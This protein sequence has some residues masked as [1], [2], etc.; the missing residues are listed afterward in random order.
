MNAKIKK[1]W[2]VIFFILFLLIFFRKTL[3]F[4]LLPIPGDLLVSFFFPYYSGGFSS[5]D[6]WTTHKGQIADDTIRQQYPWKVLTAKIWSQKELPLWNPYA[7]SGYPQAANFQTGA[8]YPLNILFIIIDPKTAWTLLIILQPILSA[9]FMY[10]FL[11]SQKM[12]RVASVFGS[13][14]FIGMSFEILWHEQMIIG[15]T[16]LWLP[17]ILLTIQ[18]VFEGR[19]K[20]L[21]LGI[22]SITMSVLAGYAQTALYV[23]ILAGFFSLLKLFAIKDSKN[24]STFLLKIIIMFLLG[25]S[26][27]AIQIIPTMEIYKYSAREGMA[28]K[29]LFTK[30]LATPRQILTLF[31]PDFFGN[32]AT[33][34]FWGDQYTDFNLFFGIV[35]LIIILTGLYRVIIN[36]ISLK[37]EKWFLILGIIALIFSF[38]TP[39]AY[40][41]YILNIPILSTGVPARFL[42]IFQFCMVIISAFC[43]NIILKKNDK[44]ISLLPSIMIFLFLLLLI[45][46]CFFI[47]YNSNNNELSNNLFVSIK[48]ISL[49][50]II[51]GGLIISLYLINKKVIIGVLFIL[52]L[53]SAEYLY[54][55][56]K[57]LPFSKKDFLY[58]DHVLFSYLKNKGID[59]F[60]GEGTARV[61]NNIPVFYNLY[62]PEGYDSLYIKRYGELIYSAVDGNIPNIIPRSDVNIIENS[63]YKE[64]ILDL[65]GVKYLVDKDDNPKETFEPDI[66]KYPRDRYKLIWQN[67]KFK[68][69]ENKKALPRIYFA[70]RI[71]VKENN[72]EIIDELYK[73]NYGKQIA[74]IEENID[75]NV[76][77]ELEPN[78]KI[79]KYSPNKIVINTNTKKNKF[80]V[81]SDNYFP[82]WKATIDG[83]DIKIYR[84]NYTFRGLIVPSGNHIL[85]FNY[86]PLSFKIGEIISVISL[87]ITFIV[88]II[89]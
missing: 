45:F 7:F 59:R 24:R 10:L 38:S 83:K 69:Y 20:W 17:L 32:V 22:L 9:F 66:I 67:G 50:L 62:Y 11:R 53:A 54:L 8:F 80:L 42:F 58:P 4:G 77:E 28:S 68:V 55:A 27:S 56:N 12:D 76:S 78:P 79:I 60:W 72:Q 63:L 29:E 2:P 89:L 26:L 35:A 41:P 87:I 43:L 33:N 65:L 25:I 34:N 49:S 1:K 75:Y 86:Q 64:K 51:A 73:N 82:G 40:I 16:T 15:H 30:F 61:G 84:T 31:S 23:L 70:D 13:L 57:Y 47:A 74:V 3:F 48:N 19:K 52:I 71:I 21:V 6:S 39:I 14:I 37:E 46:I 85:E 81:I 88:F 18:K 36:K 5:Y 44:K